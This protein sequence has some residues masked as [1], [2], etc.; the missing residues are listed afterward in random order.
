MVPAYIF[1]AVEI[2]AGIGFWLIAL[3]TLPFV[4]IIPLAL[5]ALLALPLSKL[6]SKFR[7]REL[8]TAV[9]MVA[10]VIALTIGSMMLSVSAGRVAEG[11]ISIIENMFTDAEP[12]LRLM[13]SVFPPAMWL[14]LGLT[15]A[16]D[17]A[18][19]LLLFFGVS[20][21]MMALTVYLAGK[22]YYAGV[23]AILETPR[24]KKSGKVRKT[25]IKAERPILALARSDFK[26]VLRTPIYALN[27]FSGIFIGLMV[28]VMPLIMGTDWDEFKTG[29]LNVILN[30]DPA[31]LLV[32]MTLIGSAPG[33]INPAAST[34]FSRDGRAVWL[35]QTIPVPPKI[36]VAAKILSAAAI[37]AISGIAIYTCVCI[38]F[39]QLI[40]FAVMGLIPS[41]FVAASASAM[42]MIPDIL[43]PKLKWDNEAEAM[44]Q[45][46]NAIWGML[47]SLPI[48]LIMLGVLAVI[49]L[50]APNLTLALLVLLVISAGLAYGGFYI[51]ALI[52]DSR[53]RT[54]G[55]RL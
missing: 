19:S 27:S 15:F 7:N 23:L 12:A 48:I 2:S 11:D 10:F 34:A 17:A 20:V 46:M 44:K 21:A 22:F 49:A 29:L 36:Q 8:I 26:Q 16:S 47:T 1:Y 54:K 13:T 14:A 18:I 55:E 53:F 40:P 50:S 33:L 45:N 37:G 32:I 39:P 51:A 9:F 38:I 42:S 5:S 3:L 6:A 25:D 43:S 28:F 4:P 35:M 41:I 52:A 30:T 31:L 24:K